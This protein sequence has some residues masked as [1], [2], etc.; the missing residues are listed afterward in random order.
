MELNCSSKASRVNTKK[1]FLLQ[2]AI[3]FNY[4]SQDYQKYCFYSLA[5]FTHHF[6]LQTQENRN[7]ISSLTKKDIV[8]EDSK[9]AYDEI[10]HN[11]TDF[12]IDHLPKTIATNKMFS[13]L[14]QVR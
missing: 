1:I 9:S 8:D 3:F 7:L 6:S 14:S 13:Q 4:M 11:K 12:I 5:Y 10:V 2:C